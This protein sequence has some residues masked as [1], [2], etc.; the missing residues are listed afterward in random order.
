MACR[1]KIVIVNENQKFCEEMKVILEHDYGAEVVG[2]AHNG[3]EAIRLIREKKP[4]I[5]LLDLL[6]SRYDG[7]TVLEEIADVTAGTE[8]FVMTELTSAY[9]LTALEKMG[10]S[11]V[12]IKPFCP[13]LIAQRMLKTGEYVLML[14]PEK[15]NL[16]RMV[17]EILHEIGI[18]TNLKGYHYL[19]DAIML[20]V[21]DMDRV[22]AMMRC[23]YIPIA[24]KRNATADR[25]RKNITRAIESAWN[26][27]DAEIL[28]RYFGYTII[29]TK[30]KVTNMEFIA[31]IADK[32]QLQLRSQ[33]TH[34]E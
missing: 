31:L 29:G 8:V 26:Q 4:D 33:N 27:G 30:G 23:I 24:Q 32:L 25:V 22:N 17:T 21:E 14:S 11:V 6:L 15:L 16:K 34:K 18:P 1:K 3:E 2:I 13:K 7:L 10:V 9:V 19:R 28:Q 5:L 12:F 20:A